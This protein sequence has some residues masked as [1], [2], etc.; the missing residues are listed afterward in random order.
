MEEDNN[1]DFD[2]D[3]ET[4]GEELS[5][6]HSRM[7]VGNDVVVVADRNRID[8]NEQRQEDTEQSRDLLDSEVEEGERK[9]SRE[10]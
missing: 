8:R 7:L 9:K 5:M 3:L 4:L 2:L 1:L 6:D 10:R